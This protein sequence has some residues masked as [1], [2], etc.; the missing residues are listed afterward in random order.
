[1]KTSN[2]TIVLETKFSTDRSIGAVWL[3]PEAELILR[4]LR[5]QTGLP[6]KQI[7]SEIIIQAETNIEIREVE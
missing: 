4:R 3:T 2:N 1:M 5:A 6:Y 7:V